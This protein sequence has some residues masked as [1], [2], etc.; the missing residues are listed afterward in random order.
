M[1]ISKGIIKRNIDE[2][3]LPEYKAKGYEVVEPVKDTAPKP[4]KKKP[5]DK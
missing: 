3:R 5:G 1:L 4:P 2:K